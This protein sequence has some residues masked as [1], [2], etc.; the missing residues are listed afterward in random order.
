MLPGISRNS[1]AVDLIRS[2]DALAAVLKDSNAQSMALAD[3]LLK[4][5][6]QQALSDSTVGARVDTS[7]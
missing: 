5:G 2:L 4:V 1:S 6:V 3:K 7:A